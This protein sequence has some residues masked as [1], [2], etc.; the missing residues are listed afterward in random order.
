MP[1]PL[2]DTTRSSKTRLSDL[3][4]LS[5]IA[6]RLFI[7]TASVGRWKVFCPGRLAAEQQRRE[8]HERVAAV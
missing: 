1:E 4:I 5:A 6:A 3:A 2:S 8:L 7:A